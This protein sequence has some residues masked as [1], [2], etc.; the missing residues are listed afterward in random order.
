MPVKC[1]ELQ[2]FLSCVPAALFLICLSRNQGSILT[3][4]IFDLNVVAAVQL[5]QG[6][7]NAS[8]LRMQVI[9]SV[10]GQ[11]RVIGLGGREGVGGGGDRGGARDSL[12]RL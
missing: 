1:T 7:M 6:L 3:H 4:R 5:D 9:G 12:G 8:Q 2:P 10:L 11:D